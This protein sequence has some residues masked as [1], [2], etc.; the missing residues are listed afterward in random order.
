MITQ[1]N[2][3]ATLLSVAPEGTVNPGNIDA[4]V[5]PAG[6]LATSEAE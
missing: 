1:E 5:A 6:E 4:G 2:V 3:F